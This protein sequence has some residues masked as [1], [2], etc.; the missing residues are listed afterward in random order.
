MLTL[1][2][3]QTSPYARK[4]MMVA[5]E[6]GI[7]DRMDVVVTNPWE[8]GERLLKNNP[9]SK[10]PCLVLDDGMTLVDSPVICEYLESLSSTPVLFPPVG[11]D[12]WRSLRLQAI[13]DGM[14]DAAVL[15]VL[16][17][18]RDQAHRS[19]DWEN[20]QKL[21]IDRSLDEVD[22]MAD[23]LS[24]TPTIGTISLACAL[25]YLDL[26]HGN[27]GW[28]SRAPGLAKWHAKFAEHDSYQQTQP[29]AGA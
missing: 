14:M 6:K 5:L 18:K 26:R 11:K 2:H 29:P 25:G 7:D 24:P 1:F 13:A 17:G 8:S 3:S 28:R 20:R 9:L 12:R 22:S 23:Q 16:E 19:S 21:A 4:V 27:D 15:R 10:V